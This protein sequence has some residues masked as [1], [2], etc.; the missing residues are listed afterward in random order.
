MKKK[1]KRKGQLLCHCA[2]TVVLLLTGFWGHAQQAITVQGTVLS[3]VDSTPLPSATVRLKGTPDGTLTDDNGQFKIKVEKGSILLVTSVGYTQ[4][5]VNVAQ[6]PLRIFLQPGSG[7]GALDQVVVI[8]YGS[9]RKQDV[10]GSVGI[11]DMGTVSKQPIVGAN[12]ALAGQIPGVQVNFTNGIPGGGPQVQIR[13]VGAIG[14]GSTPLYVVDGFPLSS[15]GSGSV[16]ISN[17]LNDI[18]PGDIASISVLKDASGTAIYGSRGANGVVIITTK[19]GAAGKLKFNIDAYTGI[20]QIPGK[21]VPS[22]MNATQ[23]AQFQKD[24]IEDNNALTGQNTPVPEIYQHPE[25]LG[26]GTDWFDAITRTAPM[27]SANFS[28]SGGSENFK[29]Y[30]SGGYL[31]QQGVVLATDYSKFYFRFNMIA[32]ISK[33]I[34]I[35]L[36]FAPTYSYGHDGV[37]GGNERNDAFGAWEVA[38][39]IPAIYKEDGSYND[40]IGTE[41]TWNQPNPVMVLK[42]SVHK[43]TQTHLLSSTYVNYEIIP[44]LNFKSTFN[45][46]LDNENE[47]TFTPS[48]LGSTNNPP[49]HIP[50]GS[51]AQSKY[52]NWANENSL[53][54][55]KEF[56]GGHSLTVLGVFSEQ[57]QTN[58]LAGFTGTE[59]PD[60]A[61]QTLNAAALITGGTNADSWALAS[62]LGRV[63]YAYQDKYLLTAT[64]RR[65]GSSRFGENNRWG[66]FPSFALGWD[67]AK[68]SW[69][70]SDK[71]SL[72]Q[73]KLR[74][75]YGITGND[76]IG[77]FTYLSQ[78]VSNNYVFGNSLANGRVINSISNPDL[79]W[80]RTAEVNLG[81]DL[82]FLNNKITFTADFYQSRTKS[83]LLNLNIPNSS[84]FTSTIANVGKVQ[85]KGFE[86]ALNTVN[87]STKDFNW[88]S[89][90]NFTLNRNKTLELGPNETEIQSASNMEGHPTNITRI[91]L[92]VGMLFGYKVLGLYQDADDVANSPAFPDAIAGNLKIL[93][94]NGDGEITPVTDFTII[95]NPYPKFNYGFSNNMTYKRFSLNFVFSGSYGADRLKANYASLHNIDGIFNVTTDVINRWRSEQNPGEGRVPTTAGP[96]LGRVMFRDVNS[97][98][99]YKAS[100][101]WCRNISLS[102]NLPDRFAKGFFNSV[103]VYGSVQNAFI[104]T[105]YPGNP[106]VSNYTGANGYGSALT[107][108]IDYT[109]YPV[110]RTFVFGI[111]LSY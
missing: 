3:A 88:T 63:N 64:V 43:H 68:E 48:T 50:S 44:S 95:G 101:L 10:T 14:A 71:S 75:S 60:D 28:L 87:I 91:G 1:Q 66:T 8:G 89:N 110:P 19:Q 38:N 54:Y 47:N 102:Y 24:I 82:G 61:I 26:A 15:G 39:P 103:Q 32:Q 65:D 33:K 55:K 69:M 81:L 72:S 23:F 45:V 74:A 27:T 84:G 104:I 78:L 105:N 92:P 80:E 90:F 108:G 100:Y 9:Q 111:K 79:A 59:Y 67:L 85:N 52:L 37:T 17:P 22:M 58:N 2:I 70:Q 35:G 7:K 13:G 53:T 51:F 96:S 34:S 21:Q 11:V 6:S 20:Q 46:D 109:N 86:L 49:P 30:A 93:D 42:E 76:Q 94:A 36:N 4:Q 12:E 16:Q 56:D 62:Y 18:P 107:P 41:G 106:A 29:V 97:W 31:N 73:L 40:M 25:T 5:E 83:L 99:V 57:Q 77:N 98:A